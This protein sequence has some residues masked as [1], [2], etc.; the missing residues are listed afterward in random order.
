MLKKTIHSENI[1]TLVH[2][3]KQLTSVGAKHYTCYHRNHTNRSAEEASGNKQ[4]DFY[5]ICLLMGTYSNVKNCVC[6]QKA[7]RAASQGYV[8][9]ADV[10]LQNLSS[11]QPTYVM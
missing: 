8:M 3:F 1:C 2:D 7:Q 11:C 5:L 10:I 6:V 4:K 9:D